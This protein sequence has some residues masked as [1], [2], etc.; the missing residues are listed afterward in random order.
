MG[1]IPDGVFNFVGNTIEILSAP[2]RTID[3]LSRLARVLREAREKKQS[4]EE[5]A[6]TIRKEVPELARLA[7]FLPKTRAELYSFLALIVAVITLLTQGGQSGGNT[8][9]VTV[10]QTINQVFVETDKAAKPNE[11]VAPQ[12]KQATPKVGR[13]EP[14]PCGSGKKYKKC[15]GRVQRCLTA[16]SK[17]DARNRR[18]APLL[19]PFNAN[20]E[21][22]ENPKIMQ[23]P[24]ADRMDII[25]R[26]DDLSSAEVQSLIA[27][28]L[29]GMHS[30]SPP[31]HVNA[32][33]IG[34][35]R[36]PSVTFW[37]AWMDGNLCGCGA[38]KELDRFTGEIKSMRTRPAFLRC[39]I[40]QAIL[41]E[42]IRTGRQRGY[43]RL[44]LETGTGPAFDAAHAFYLCNGFEWS[45]QF[46]EY[47][48][49]DFNVFMAKI[50]T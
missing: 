26:Q 30:N 14:C 21:T 6:A 7:D 33:A 20:V 2:R 12:V 46:G 11:K 32:L 13:N 34:S 45:G 8:S 37:C 15:C 38:L 39:G 5:V 22:E 9:N 25:V 43:S 28:H 42:I 41:D 17:T 50:L 35:L 24:G 10:N 4:P 1:H 18:C 47:T 16:R 29:A 27:E 48:A 44:L 3:E 36:M 49:T 31:G 19:A 23:I 40:G